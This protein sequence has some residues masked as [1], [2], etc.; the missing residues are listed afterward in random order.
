M[1][2]GFFGMALAAA[3][4]AWISGAFPA[5][6]ADAKSAP[7]LGAFLLK[8]GKV[9]KNKTALECEV[10]EIEG[11]GAFRFWSAFGPETSEAVAENETGV[12]LFSAK[13]ACVRFVALDSENEAQDVLPSADGKAFVLV[14]GSGMRADVFFNVYG[15]GAEKL[16]ELSGV[17]G[18]I[19]WLDAGRFAFARIDDTR[20][21][22]AAAGNWL[23]TS[24]VLYDTAAKKE[25]VLKKA[26]DKLNYAEPA[27]TPGENSITVTEEAVKSAKE[28]KNDDKVKRKEI[29]VPIPAK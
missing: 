10:H 5:F 18:Q 13:G 3:A 7:N 28:W 9:F 6:A 15:E 27:L 23:K 29:K 17:L 1:K 26:T 2:K 11:K 8:D 22:D 20:E 24:L 19:V 12:C 16:A 4:A 21:V 14:T 25:T